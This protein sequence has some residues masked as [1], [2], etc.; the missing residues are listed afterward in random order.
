[1]RSGPRG[2]SAPDAHQAQALL[3]PQLLSDSSPARPRGKP[4]GL[5]RAHSRQ[6]RRG[7]AKAPGATKS[8]ERRCSGAASPSARGRRQPG[9]I[10]PPLRPARSVPRRAGRG[11]L[12]QHR[13][14][15]TSPRASRKLGPSFRAGRAVSSFLPTC[16]GSSGPI[17]S[18][19]A[20]ATSF[21]AAE[22]WVLVPLGPAREL[23]VSSG[24]E[25]TSPRPLMPLPGAVCGPGRGGL[26]AERGRDGEWS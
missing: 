7:P 17:L 4:E 5:A 16:R 20:A 24:P 13:P 8:G 6:P 1:M 12:G 25:P 11:A 22:A 10:A 14:P 2:A 21:S 15:L 26:E 23:A 19:R 18:P 9:A 3:Y